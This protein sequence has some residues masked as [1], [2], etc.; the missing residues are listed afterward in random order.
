MVF[1]SC[2]IDLKKN[3]NIHFCSSRHRS[4]PSRPLSSR[5]VVVIVAASAEMVNV[6]MVR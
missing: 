6:G 3:K 5:V 1:I 2:I 4:F